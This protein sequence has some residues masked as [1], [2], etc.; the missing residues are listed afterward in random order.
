MNKLKAVPATPAKMEEPHNGPSYCAWKSYTKVL[1][2]SMVL[3]ALLLSNAGWAIDQMWATDQAAQEA[4]E[5]ERIY[6]GQLMTDQER[7]AY[8][9][10]MRAAASEEEREEIRKEHHTFMQERAQAQGITLPEEQPQ[11]MKHHAK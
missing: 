8:H 6:G 2:V 4:R 11:H 7:A 10:K 9:E 5:Q 3:N 1:V